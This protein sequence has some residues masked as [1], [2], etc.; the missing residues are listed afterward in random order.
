VIRHVLGAA[1]GFGLHTGV[2]TLTVAVERHHPMTL[3]VGVAPSLPFVVNVVTAAI[4]I[5]LA[6]PCP[7]VGRRV[8]AGPG[9]P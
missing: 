8:R 3:H 7:A 5:D 6:L 4:G 1:D 9:P 2:A